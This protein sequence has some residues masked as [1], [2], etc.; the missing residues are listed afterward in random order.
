M[1]NIYGS[2]RFANSGPK[3]FCIGFNKTGTFSLHRFFQ[4]CGLS[5]EHSTIWPLYSQVEKGKRYFK[6]QCYSDGEQSDVVNLSQWFPGSIFILNNRDERE[7][8]YSRIKCNEI[9]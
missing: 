3:V 5:S 9:Q 6:K 2:T 8:L 1:Q 7:W 4:G